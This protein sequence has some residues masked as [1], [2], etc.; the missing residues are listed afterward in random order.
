LEINKANPQNGEFDEFIEW[1]NSKEIPEMVYDHNEIL[2]FALR[3]IEKNL[4]ESFLTKLNSYFMLAQ[5]SEFF[6]DKSNFKLLIKN[7]NL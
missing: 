1:R 7:R 4:K 6:I 5:K 3:I 2:N